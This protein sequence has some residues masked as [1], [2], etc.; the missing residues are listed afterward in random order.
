MPLCFALVLLSGEKMS[1]TSGLDPVL[2]FLLNGLTHSTGWQIFIYSMIVTHITIAGVTIFL[3][4]CQA[5]RALDLQ[6]YLVI[7]SVF[8]CG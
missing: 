8:G 3:H 6:R 7:F 1:L 4:R 5:H 2:D